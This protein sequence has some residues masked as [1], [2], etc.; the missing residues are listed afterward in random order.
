[1]LASHWSCTNVFSEE[2]VVVAKGLKVMEVC[3]LAAFLLYAVLY[4]SAITLKASFVHFSF[5]SPFSRICA[6]V[7]HPVTVVVLS[8]G[9][10]IL[11]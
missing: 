10:Y 4:L 5:K 1:M 7:L 8:F 9:D 3:H 11:Y 6:W 2:E